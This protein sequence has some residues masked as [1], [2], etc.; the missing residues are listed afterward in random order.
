MSLRTI[1]LLLVS[2]LLAGCVGPDAY[3]RGAEIGDTGGSPGTGTGGVGPGTGGVGS[4]TGGVVGSGNGGTVG[5]GNGGSGSGGTVGS[6]NGGAGGRGGTT[7]TTG[8]G[9]TVGS[10]T[11]GSGTGGVGA[12]GT[13]PATTLLVDTFEPGTNDGKHSWISPDSTI[14]SWALVADGANTV[15]REGTVVSSEVKSISGNLAWTNQVIEVRA[16]VTGGDIGSVRVMV[17]GR[18]TDD[19]NY[20]FLEMSQSQIKVRKKIAGSSVDIG[21]YKFPSTAP[22]QPNTWYTVKLELVGSTFRGWFNGAPTDPIVDMGTP[23]PMGGIGVGVNDGSADF[24]DVKVT[25]Q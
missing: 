22:L 14:G 24:D 16:R 23:F 4:G 20:F 6:G 9:G 18:Y 17:Y 10:G 19:K 25:S 11:G 12:G 5:T 1:P 3:Y 13:G 8:G 21:R 7:A 2:S 15:F